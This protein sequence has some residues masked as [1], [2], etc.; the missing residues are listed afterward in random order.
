MIDPELAARVAVY[1]AATG[2]TEE[3]A[4]QRILAIGMTTWETDPHFM[5]ERICGRVRTVLHSNV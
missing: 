4:V 1:C 3:E 2:H 5:P